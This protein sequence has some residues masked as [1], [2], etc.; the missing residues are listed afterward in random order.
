MMTKL[1]H[2]SFCIVLMGLNACSS[3]ESQKNNSSVENQS[4]DHSVD[5]TTVPEQSPVIVPQ[6]QVSPDQSWDLIESTVTRSNAM[7]FYPEMDKTLHFQDPSDPTRDFAFTENYDLIKSK[8]H[9][10]KDQMIL[11][12]LTDSTMQDNL[13]LDLSDTEYFKFANNLAINYIRA[14]KVAKVKPKQEFEKTE[15]YEERLKAAQ[16]KIKNTSTDYD[17]ELLERILNRS[18]PD[19]GFISPGNSYSYDADQ[20]L[21]TI[22]I[23]QS[24]SPYVAVIQSTLLLKIQPDL[25]KIIAEEFT[26]LRLGYVLQFKNNQLK[27]DGVFFYYEKTVA[28]NIQGDPTERVM[29]ISPVFKPISF[30]QKSAVRQ[31]SEDLDASEKIERLSFKEVNSSPVWQFKFGLDNYL[32]PET[33]FK[34]YTQQQNKSAS[35]VQD[36]ADALEQS[37]AQAATGL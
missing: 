11:I 30:K 20:E 36:E 37:E 21:M 14:L 34:Q 15:A 8:L 17:A 22:H 12:G 4:T 6:A 35:A 3:Q 9:L 10:A 31:I 13:L 23:Q 27:L 18:V 33:L 26:Q 7:L 32:S 1:K 2:L 25:A 29:N 28:S 24:S 5:Q 16:E 19:I